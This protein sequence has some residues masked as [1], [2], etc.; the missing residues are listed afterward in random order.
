MFK[1]RCTA[2]KGKPAAKRRITLPHPSY[3]P[4]KAALEEDVRIDVP[5]DTL[6]EKMENLARAVLQPVEIVYV[7]PPL[8]RDRPGK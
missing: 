4:S 1:F 3:Q 7:D 5:G 6:E 2:K 8:G